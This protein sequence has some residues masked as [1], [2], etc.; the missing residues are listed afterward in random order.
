MK[1]PEWGFL[2]L[3]LSR[4]FGT[5]I[6]HPD[7]TVNKRYITAINHPGIVSESKT[8]FSIRMNLGLDWITTSGKK[9][10]RSEMMDTLVN[11][12]IGKYSMYIYIYT[13]VGQVMKIY[14]KSNKSIAG[15]HM[16][17]LNQCSSTFDASIPSH[18]A[19][20]HKR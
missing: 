8:K 4:C 16:W 5:D 20:A 3:A 11:K 14:H 6:H 18:I 19:P 17:Q 7:A 13:T 10:M 12:P 1:Q 15:P 9:N 2:L